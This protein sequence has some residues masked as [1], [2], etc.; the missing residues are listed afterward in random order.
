MWERFIK[1]STKLFRK[2][3]IFQLNATAAKLVASCCMI[4]CTMRSYTLA[5]FLLLIAFVSSA[6]VRLPKLIS[7]GMVIQRDR[8][9][10]VW[11]WA[12]PGEKISVAFQKKSFKT[13]AAADGTWNVSLAAMKSGGPHN[14]MI[15]GNGQPIEIRDILIGDVWFFSGQSNM[16]ITMERVKEKYPEEIRDANYPQIRNF[17]VPTYSDVTKTHA[18]L[19]GGS[20]IAAAP[21]TIFGFGAVAYFFARALHQ[22]YKVPIGIINASVGGTPVE[23]WVS[24]EGLKGFSDLSALVLQFHDSVHMAD[25]MKR[26]SIKPEQPK[27]EPDKGMTEKWYEPALSTSDWD[28]F[29]LPGYWED[30]GV[31]GLHGNV[32]FRKEINLPESFAGKPAKLFM[33]RIVDA[34]EVYV[35]GTKVGNITY[36]YPPRRYTVNERLLKAGS[37]TIVVHVTNFAGKGGFVPDKPYWLVA[38]IDSVDLRGLW[39][40]KV[41]NV[42]PKDEGPAPFRFSAQS[43]PTGLYNTMVAPVIN[44]TIRGINWYQGETNTNAPGNY[45]EYLTAL[46]ADWRSKWNDTALPFAYVQLANFMEVQYLPMES[47]WAELR[48]EQRQ[49]LQVSNTAMAVAIDLG[50]W[51]DIHPLNKKDVGERLALAQRHLSYGDDVVFSGPL[52]ESSKVEGNNVVIK[53]SHV[54]GGLVAKGGDPLNYFEVAG[55]DG[56]YYSAKATIDGDKVIVWSDKVNSPRT[57][58]YAWADNPKGA[59]LYNKE[60][61]PASP[62]QT[63]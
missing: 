4:C 28:D 19:P 39:K 46:I 44:Y 63:K 6:D 41:G 53:F 59:N 17:L 12:S 42:F 32:W 40:Y 58:R 23:A 34:D 33:G 27:I 50:E 62:F 48:D 10:R 60:G 36:Q 49:V 24:A 57:A 61:L 51:N 5:M 14:M 9:V 11:G 47:N 35:N 45:A 26:A 18:D 56:K 13:T 2:E 22:Q 21:E 3:T 43:S 54:G 52:Y 8:P 31:K 1:Q 25:V 15:K 38:G 20:W 37:N 16:V 29:W 30:Q 7:N 55:E